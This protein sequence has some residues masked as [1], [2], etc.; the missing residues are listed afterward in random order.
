MAVGWVY[1]TIILFR[2]VD[3]LAYCHWCEY[4]NCIEADFLPWQ[5]PVTVNGTVQPAV[6][7]S[8]YAKPDPQL[9]KC[10]NG[11]FKQ[12]SPSQEDDVQLV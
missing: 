9:L 12:L 10:P 6:Q 7:C 3:A 5:C 1:V 2:E 11:K 4:I 8:H